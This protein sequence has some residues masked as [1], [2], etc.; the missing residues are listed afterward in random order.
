MVVGRESPISSTFPASPVPSSGLGLADPLW[1]PA[2][3]SPCPGPA[4]EPCKASGC[5]QGHAEVCGSAG[6]RRPGYVAPTPSPSPASALS[7]T[8]VAYPTNQPQFLN[9][10]CI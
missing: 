5:D 8:I 10:P 4:A 3:T 2:A 7:L 1:L 6:D 9:L